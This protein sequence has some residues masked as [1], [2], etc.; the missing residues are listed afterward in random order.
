MNVLHSI[1]FVFLSTFSNNLGDN[2]KIIPI[3]HSSFNSASNFVKNFKK[4]FVSNVETR[5]KAQPFLAIAKYLRNPEK[6]AQILLVTFKND[7]FDRRYS[8]SVVKKLDSLGIPII[9]VL[10]E[11]KRK[12]FDVLR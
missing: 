12:N 2:E 7:K 5:K 8:P 3:V 11:N 1:V 9:S 6:N 10:F 4:N